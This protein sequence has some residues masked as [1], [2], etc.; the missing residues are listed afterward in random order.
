MCPAGP[1]GSHRGP[2]ERGRDLGWRTEGRHRGHPSA[3]AP[4]CLLRGGGTPS[5]AQEGLPGSP[6]S[7]REMPL[8][9]SPG[10]CLLG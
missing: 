10:S 3:C 4:A 5:G 7:W 8:P 2:C 1:Q 6:A 9:G